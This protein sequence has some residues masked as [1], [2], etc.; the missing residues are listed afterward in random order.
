MSPSLIEFLG[1]T[2]ALMLALCALPEVI[3]SL[4]TKK[5]TVG[6][7]MLSLWWIGEIFTLIFIAARAPE[8]QLVVNYGLN[9][10]FV[11]ILIF[12]KWKGTHGTR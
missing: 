12:Y 1:W 8:I 10:A 4:I 9:F 3:S 5:C 11:S 2:G 6:W 7:G